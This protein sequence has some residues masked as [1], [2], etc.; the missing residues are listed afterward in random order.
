MA[1][2]GKGKGG[3]IAVATALITAGGAIAVAL[4]NKPEPA[5]TSQ[6]DNIQPA[7][8]PDEN[9]TEGTQAP[10]PAPQVR[11]EP[12]PSI[13]P[14]VQQATMIDVTGTWSEMSGAT[15][16]FSQSGDTLELQYN[17]LPAF[18][19][20]FALGEGQ[21]DGRSIQWAL[22]YPTGAVQNCTATLSQSGNRM[23]GQCFNNF[24]VAAPIILT[25]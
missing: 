13:P 25:R 1:Q 7:P 24:G 23:Q 9:N 11:D 12:A 17:I 8:Q 14:V 10:V 4:I 15:A 18:G 20:G 3:L 6:I 22:V 16:E 19:G 21:I 2:D 5:P